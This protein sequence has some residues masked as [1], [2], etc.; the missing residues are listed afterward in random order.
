MSMNISKVPRRAV[1]LAAI[2]ATLPAVALA[3]A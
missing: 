2:A 3:Q 1:A